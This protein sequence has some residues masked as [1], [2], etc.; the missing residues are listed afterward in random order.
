M[1][2]NPIPLS[3]YVHIPWCIQKCPYCDFNSHALNDS[4]NE[5]QYIS[6][7]L[8]DIESSLELTDNRRLSSIF[9]GGG[10]P[11]LFSPKNYDV[12]LQALE[13]KIGFEKEI[14]ITL[15]AN[16]GTVDKKNFADYRKIGINRL[17]LGIQSFNNLMLKRLGRIHDSDTAKQAINTAVNAGFDNFNLDL[18]HGL[19]NQT[20][21]EAI[22][23]LEMALSFNPPHLSWYQ[24]TIEPNTVFYKTRPSLPS[25]DILMEIEQMGLG[26]LSNYQRY[27]V[28]AYA[29]EKNAQC[30]HNLNYWQF[31]DY[32][33]IGAGAHGKIT[34][35]D[36]KQ[37][38][39]T[40]KSRLP[41]HYL[42]QP[43]AS[44]TTAVPE[45]ER[46]FEFMLNALRLKKIHSFEHFEQRSLCTISQIMPTLE[47][48]QNL[49]LMHFS[50]QKF[51]LTAKGELFLNDVI[52]LFLQT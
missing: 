29:L 26:C 33:G 49:E 45:K 13:S 10:T 11:S 42:A 27:E 47:N 34:L 30:K 40:Q 48:A 31:G 51:G 37:I 43:Q 17:S 3:L 5:Q 18:M 15:E 12:L 4:V 19:P 6:A 2:A 14:E 46:A 38:I 25:E 7:L 52:S 39:R 41:K 44:K 50:S 32:L 28:S 21:K 8:T 20:P 23:D 22:S 35:T 24:L 16:P 36:K 9:I 1:L